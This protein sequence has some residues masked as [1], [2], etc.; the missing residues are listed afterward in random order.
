M[1][2]V[3]ALALEPNSRGHA[4]NTATC[5][6]LPAGTVAVFTDERA[7][8]ERFRTSVAAKGSGHFT[9]MAE[10]DPART[11][12]AALLNALQVNDEP[13][14]ATQIA[15]LATQDVGYTVVQVELAA[16]GANPEV[17]RGFMERVCPGELGAA[18]PDYRGWGAALVRATP[19]CTRI[20]QAPHVRDD[21]LSEDIALRAFADDPHACVVMFAGASRFVVGTPPAATPADVAHT[22][23]NLFHALT[24]HLATADSPVRYW[25]IQ[26]HGMADR[27]DEPSIVGS[28]GAGTN[29]TVAVP[30]PPD[31]ECEHP[32]ERI[33]D[34]VDGEGRLTMGVWGWGTP[35]ATMACDP[36]G[37]QEDGLYSLVA[38]T[39]VQGD[40]LAATPSPSMR[41]CFMHFEIER[42]PRVEYATTVADPEAATSAGYLGILDLMTAIRM[43]LGSG[44]CP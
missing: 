8:L 35:D 2:A 16:G 27:D 36:E 26:I 25:F 34:A 12:F 31:L 43:T 4:A 5:A 41:D 37:E 30:N 13:G 18:E 20:Y 22:T 44:A 33:D 40:Y 1:F 9:P 29:P 19:G 3:L 39:N 28:N 32:L 23:D 42:S 7:F 15:V 24:M 17:V 6:T 11:P 14:A 38:T 10:D 21:W